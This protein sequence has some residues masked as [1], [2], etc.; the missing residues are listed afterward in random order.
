MARANS[1]FDIYDHGGPEIQKICL[2]VIQ[3]YI[4]PSEE[5]YGAAFLGSQPFL[6]STLIIKISQEQ[7]EKMRKGSIHT[8]LEKLNGFSQLRKEGER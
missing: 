2:S 7:S 8:I 5:R 1:S 4:H 3:I 6:H